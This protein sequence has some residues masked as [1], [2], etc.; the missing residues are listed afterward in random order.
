[1]GTDRTG[2]LCPPQGSERKSAE[3][4]GRSSEGPSSSLQENSR[5]PHRC[6]TRRQQRSNSV[7]CVG[8]GKPASARRGRRPRLSC[9]TLGTPANPSLASTCPCVPARDT[10]PRNGIGERSR[11]ADDAF[12]RHPIISAISRRMGPTW[13]RLGLPGFPRQGP[14]RS[15]DVGRLVRV[16]Y[17]QRS[18]SRE[19]SRCTCPSLKT[20]LCH[21]HRMHRPLLGE[22]S[23]SMRPMPC[24]SHTVDTGTYAGNAGEKRCCGMRH[25]Q[26][27]PLQGGMEEVVRAAATLLPHAAGGRTGRTAARFRH[28]RKKT[29][30]LSA[31]VRRVIVP[32][33][34]F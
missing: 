8:S 11:H 27:W 15:C 4:E 32:G 7:E 10:T 23:A 13:D 1:M 2:R 3:K 18:P 28:H 25:A 26:G 12:R 33:G 20:S 9:R 5:R 21:R 31:S 22:L 19:G 17:P 14:A 16:L 30:I 34:M 24:F 29:V 6:P